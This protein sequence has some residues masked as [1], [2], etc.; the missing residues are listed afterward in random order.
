MTDDTKKELKKN[1]MFGYAGIFPE[2]SSKSNLEILEVFLDE[3]IPHFNKAY[4]VEAD[5]IEVS[6]RD[7][8]PKDFEEEIYGGK[9]DVVVKE[10]YLPSGTI[11]V[12]VKS[13][14]ESEDKSDKKGEN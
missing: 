10:K 4:G 3:H 14:M 11:F 7:F 13:N 5:F 1:Q 6:G 9:L 8:S 2:K 12:G